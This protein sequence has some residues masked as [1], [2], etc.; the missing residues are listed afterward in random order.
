MLFGWNK[1]PPGLH[2]FTTC[3]VALEHADVNLL[4]PRVQ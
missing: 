3:M 2:F 1:V 4:D